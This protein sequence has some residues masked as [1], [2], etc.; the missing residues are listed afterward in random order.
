MASMLSRRGSSSAASSSVAARMAARASSLRGRPRLAGSVVV[1][2]QVYRTSSS[3]YSVS[4]HLVRKGS[5]VST[6]AFKDRHVAVIGGTTGIGLATAR[7]LV[8]SGAR[9]TIAGRDPE[10]LAQ[11][12]ASLADEVQ[13][14]AVDA[15]DPDAL[16]RFFVETGP[17]DDLVVTVTRRGGAGPASGLADQDLLDAFTGKTVAHLRAVAVALPTLETHGSITL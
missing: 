3:G 1:I 11:A 12:R 2:L 13:A 9:A 15:T 17:I 8:A 14:I 5:A 16:R 4:E 10:R 6:T 7:L